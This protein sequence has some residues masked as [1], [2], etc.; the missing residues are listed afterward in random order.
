MRKKLLLAFRGVIMM[1]VVLVLTWTQVRSGPQAS[2]PTPTYALTL[3][4]NDESLLPVMPTAIQPKLVDLAPQIPYEDKP[5]VVVQHPDGSRTMYLVA[6]DAI[7]GF[8]ENLP[9]GDE[10]KLLISPPSLMGHEPPTVTL[11][12]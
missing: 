3:G 10:L 9:E 12:P 8:I 4:P 2:T 5:A 6:P 1:I 11:E 7:D